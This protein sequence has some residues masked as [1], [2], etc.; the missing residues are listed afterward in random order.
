MGPSRQHTWWVVGAVSL[1]AGIWFLSSSRGFS[2]SDLMAPKEPENPVMALPRPSDVSGRS[3]S[4]A[5]AESAMIPSSGPV[6]FAQALGQCAPSTPASTPQELFAQLS[7]AGEIS[8]DVAMEN[9]HLRRPD[10][11]EE[12]LMLIPSDKPDAQGKNEIRWF[13]VDDEGLP[14]PQKLPWQK[15]FNPSAEFLDELKSR[16]EIFFHQTKQQIIYKNQISANVELIND[17]IQE[18]QIYFPDKTLS[19][20]GDRCQCR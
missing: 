8:H 6:T 7:Q 9:W 11:S 18:F 5:K 1:L 16:G 2:A 15:A 14:V 17:K 13:T 19:C 12:R 20:R 10:G 4:A 3:S